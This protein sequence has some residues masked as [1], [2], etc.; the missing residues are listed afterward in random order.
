MTGKTPYSAT[1]SSYANVLA[2]SET[3][4]IVQA[5]SSHC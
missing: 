5:K 1:V 2:V 3:V 4:Q